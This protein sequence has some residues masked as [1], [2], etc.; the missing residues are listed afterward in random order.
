MNRTDR[1]RQFAPF[2]ALKGLQEALRLKEYEHERK[3]KGGLSEEQI[4]E[5]SNTLSLLQ[6]NDDIKLKYYY[7][8]H[9]KTIEG[10]CKIDYVFQFIEINKV[11]IQFDDIYEIE[12]K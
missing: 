12:K 10:K 11:K 9:Y 6:K 5:I 2:D 8:G 7:D 1:A 3:D 4:S